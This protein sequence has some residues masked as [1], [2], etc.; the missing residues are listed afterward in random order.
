VK[1]N[2]R[3][4]RPRRPTRWGA[5]NW[6]HAGCRYKKLQTIAR[7]A[8]IRQNLK[9]RFVPCIHN[10]NEERNVTTQ[11]G[12]KNRIRAGCRYKILQITGWFAQ[13]RQNLMTRF[14]ANASCQRPDEARRIG[15]K[16]GRDTQY[17]QPPTGLHEFIKISKYD[18]FLVFTNKMTRD[19]APPK[20]ARRIEFGRGAATRLC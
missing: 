18:L 6:I 1:A 15:F 17:C 7:F 10:Q 16:R 12:A 5:K 11:A 14:P 3:L 13:F 8:Q 4:L 2:Q 20:Q 19:T 9:V